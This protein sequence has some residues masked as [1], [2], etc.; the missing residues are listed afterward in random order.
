M[1][2]LSL[3]SRVCVCVNIALF[4]YLFISIFSMYSQI[5]TL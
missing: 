3:Y 1:K 2:L 5:S 4:V